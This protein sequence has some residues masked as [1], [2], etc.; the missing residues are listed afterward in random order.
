MEAASNYV[1]SSDD[2]DEPPDLGNDRPR[3][4][5]PKPAR[6]QNTLDRWVVGAEALAAPEPAPAEGWLLIDLFC[7]VGGV[8]AAA[9]AEGH[10]VV[11]AIDMEQWR[12]DVHAANH[13]HARHECLKLGAG[14]ED[15][16]RELIHECV[17]H[18]QWHR[19]WIH[20]SPPCTCQSGIVNIGEKRSHTNYKQLDS[21][22]KHNHDLVRWSLEVVRELAP[23]QFSLEE[24]DDRSRKGTGFDRDSGVRGAL[25]AMKRADRNS[26]DYD[27]FNMVDFGV[28][29][30]RQRLIAGRPATIAQ[31][32]NAAALRVSRPVTAFEALCAAGCAPEQPD[33]RYIM[34]PFNRKPDPS[35]VVPTAEPGR[36]TDGRCG[37]YDSHLLPAPTLTGGNHFTWVQPDFQSTSHCLTLEQASALMTFPRDFKWVEEPRAKRTSA[38]QRRSGVGNAVPPFFMRKVFRAASALV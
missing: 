27:V 10:T 34:G 14:A 21:D 37:Y 28:P 38:K 8:S 2:D 33:H 29:Q 36:F 13:P 16:V 1:S 31:L 23:P 18:D 20:M 26:L 5:P 25:Q 3:T 12:L 35:K 7:S 4:P 6:K 11:L 32:R 17:P 9:A 19:L 15:R 30:A 24:V 22:R